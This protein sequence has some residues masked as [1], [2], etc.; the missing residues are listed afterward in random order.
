MCI[1]AD[2]C[3]LLC[4]LLLSADRL[5]RRPE[6]AAWRMRRVSDCRSHIAERSNGAIHR[7]CLLPWSCTAGC[8]RSA[9]WRHFH[10][11]ASEWLLRHYLPCWLHQQW[12]AHL[13]HCMLAST[14]GVLRKQLCGGTAAAF[15]SVRGCSALTLRCLLWLMLSCVCISNSACPQT[16][17][18]YDPL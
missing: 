7:S 18:Q 5:A 9:P 11:C 6:L 4:L 14:N 3:A 17:L 2:G 10:F 13:A 12:S 8:A 1:C 15:V 16:M